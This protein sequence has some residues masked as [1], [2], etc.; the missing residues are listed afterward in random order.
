MVAVVVELLTNPTSKSK[1]DFGFSLKSQL[2]IYAAVPQVYAAV[3]W[4]YADVHWVYAALPSH[5]DSELLLIG[6]NLKNKSSQI[7]TKL[8]E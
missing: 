2:T 1:S 4:V 8:S 3:P 6:K 5:Y 7:W